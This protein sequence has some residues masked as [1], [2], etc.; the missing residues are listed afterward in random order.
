M[1]FPSSL[2]AAV[3]CVIVEAA[4]VAQAETML[5]LI[6]NN[7]ITTPEMSCS[8]VDNI[9]I[10]KVFDRPLNRRNLRSNS[11]EKVDRPMDKLHVIDHSDNNNNDEDRHLQ[12]V[13]TASYCRD[14]CRGYATGHCYKTGCGWYNNKR[15]QLQNYGKG[16]ASNSTLCRTTADSISSDL[17]YI[18]SQSLVSSSCVALLQ[19]PRKIE[20]FEDVMYGIVDAFK[21]IDADT[22]TALV[23]FLN[24]R[25]TICNTNAFNFQVLV[26]SCVNSVN[27]TLYNRKA[28][29]YSTV[30]RNTTIPGPYTLFG[31]NGTS[32]KNFDGQQIP[33]GNFTIEAT[34]DGYTNK[35][36]VRNFFIAQC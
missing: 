34:P 4:Y 11:V 10:S 15:R 18:M 9:L 6:L 29:Y 12:F 30:I 36:R 21:V 1:K 2:V 13:G 20:C 23:S 26:N 27:I 22:D 31:M 8:A 28:N 3:I 17:D 35:T 14:E 5:R 32:T 33:L 19:A 7:G 16:F 24:A 25:Q